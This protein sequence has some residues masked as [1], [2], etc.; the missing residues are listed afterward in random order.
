[1]PVLICLREKLWTRTYYIGDQVPTCPVL[2]RVKIKVLFWD[3]SQFAVTLYIICN[4]IIV[5]SV[6][7]CWLNKITIRKAKTH[8]PVDISSLEETFVNLMFR[9]PNDVC[10]FFEE[11]QKGPKKSRKQSNFSLHLI[12][13]AQIIFNNHFSRKRKRRLSPV[14]N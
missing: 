14:F 9:P 12:S 6:Q 8:C 13:T 2:T 5:T 3:F 11:R 1:M 4:I 10:A 7:F